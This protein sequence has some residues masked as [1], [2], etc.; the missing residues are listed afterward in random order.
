[1][2][3]RSMGQI[4]VEPFPLAPNVE[5]PKVKVQDWFGLAVNICH[6]SLSDSGEG[7]VDLP[8]SAASSIVH[9]LRAMKFQC[10][11]TGCKTPLFNTDD[12]KYYAMCGPCGERH[13]R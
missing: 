11:C 10:L 1:M 13:D 6:G 7:R 12:R 9:E 5:P 4:P 2:K 3:L 8:E